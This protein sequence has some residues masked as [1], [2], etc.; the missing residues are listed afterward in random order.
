[1]GIFDMTGNVWEWC[2]DWYDAN[3]YAGRPDLD[4]NPKGATTGQYRV[5]RG[6]FWLYNPAR[7]RVAYRN[8]V[9]P[10]IRDSSLG[11]RLVLPSR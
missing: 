9:S 5:S 8:W 2:Q 4:A 10:D 11:F 1:L 6:G 3:Y 7:C